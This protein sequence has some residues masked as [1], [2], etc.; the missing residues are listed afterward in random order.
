M[1]D[2]A[3]FIHSMLPFVGVAVSNTLYDGRVL[4]IRLPEEMRGQFPEF[5]QRTVVRITTDRA[6]ARRLA[7]VIL[8]DFEASFFR[9]LIRSAQ[10]PAFGGSYAVIPA[11]QED[12]GAL[13]AYKLRWQNDQGEPTIEEFMVVHTGDTPR[14]S[15]NPS[16]VWEL[17]RRPMAGITLQAPERNDG[18][19][20]LQ[21][22]QREV[23][24]RLG[25][26]S[27]RFKHPNG[28]VLL[29]A[30][31]VCMAGGGVPAPIP[32]TRG[33]TMRRA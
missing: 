18:R 9:H 20:I 4:E 12:Q 14:V 21:R 19:E 28:F 2:V 8:L 6:L 3:T 32:K 7:D 23:E 11:Y 13:A 15:V 16:F 1:R 24:G 33:C 27:S 10:D 30:A 5:Q 17:L 22:I 25:S 31:D 26:E 29:A